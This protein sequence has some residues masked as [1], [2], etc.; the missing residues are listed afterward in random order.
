[1]VRTPVHRVIHIQIL[2]HHVQSKV[3]IMRVLDMVIAK[4]SNSLMKEFDSRECITRIPD[5]LARIF[6]NHDRKKCL[7][8]CA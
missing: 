3:R 2:L 4:V 5:K 1:M 7:G 6:F 8:N